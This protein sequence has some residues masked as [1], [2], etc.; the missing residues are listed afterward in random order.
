MRAFSVDTPPIFIESHDVTQFC[1][2]VRDYI[3]EEMDGKTVTHKQFNYVEI[4]GEI[5]RE[6]IIEAL[7]RDKYDIDQ[8]SKIIAK[9][10][11]STAYRKYKKFVNECEILADQS[12][13]SLS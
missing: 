7:I 12:I 10:H 6:K 1:Y 3:Q 13:K 5:T 8:E 11:N 2:N 9:S 4:E